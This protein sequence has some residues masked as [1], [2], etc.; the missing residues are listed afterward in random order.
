VCFRADEIFRS[1][2][3]IVGGS[4]ASCLRRL[5]EKRDRSQPPTDPN[6]LWAHDTSFWN[7]FLETRMRV[8]IGD[9]TEVTQ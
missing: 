4:A 1:G 5:A 3:A 7:S 6:H 2:I 9:L 8:R